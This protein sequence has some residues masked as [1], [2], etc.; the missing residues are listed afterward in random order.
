MARIG[1]TGNAKIAKRALARIRKVKSKKGACKIAIKAFAEA[2]AHT[3]AAL[4]GGERAKGL[5]K[6]LHAAEKRVTRLCSEVYV[7]IARRKKGAT[8]RR[9]RYD[10]DDFDWEPAPRVTAVRTAPARAAD[11]TVTTRFVAGPSG[12]GG[13]VF[14]RAAWRAATTLDGLRRRRSR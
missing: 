9:A 3:G 11:A 10:L 1:K 4:H 6:Q 14:D 12:A 13:Q 7:K 5:H 8:R 2:A